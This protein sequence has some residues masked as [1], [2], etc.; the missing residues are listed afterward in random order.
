MEKKKNSR[1]KSYVIYGGIGLSLCTEMAVAGLLGWWTGKWA[2]AKFSM[3]P[4][5]TTLGIL[6][7]V[8]IS[9]VHI[10]KT[11]KDVADRL[12]REDAE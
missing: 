8:S 3:R 9:F 1:L 5:G 2:D 4:W 6:V 10:L 11:L 7:F 12:D